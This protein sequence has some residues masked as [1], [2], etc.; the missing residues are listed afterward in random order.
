MAATLRELLESY[1][2]PQRLAWRS[3]RTSD[4]YASLLRAID[5]H[6][7]RPATVGD[8]RDETIAGYLLWQR[9]RGRAPATVDKHRRYCRALSRYAARHGLIERPLELAPIRATVDEPQPWSTDELALIMAR[10]SSLDGVMPGPA[11]IPASKFWTA[12][13]LVIVSTGV[14]ISACLSLRWQDV[15]LCERWAIFR[16]ETQKHRRTQKLALNDQAVRALADI[17]HPDRE[18]VYDVPLCAATLRR[19]YTERIL[20]PLGL[21]TDRRSKFH[22]LRRTTATLIAQHVGYDAASRQLGHSSQA[23]LRYY[24]PA[25]VDRWIDRVPLPDSQGGPVFV[26]P[27]RL[28]CACAHAGDRPPINKETK[29]EVLQA[30]AVTKNGSL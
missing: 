24:V 25:L 30:K 6:L 9:G 8:L 19:H 17:R 15:N 26:R 18:R 13:V 29:D 27:D 10:A 3:P 11:Q 2:T 20:R 5:S 23:L 7:G 28:S 22:Q 21:R 4:D 14:R 1:Y 12:L 16:G